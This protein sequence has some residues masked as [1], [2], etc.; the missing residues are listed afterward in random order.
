MIMPNRL[1][2][3]VMKLPSVKMNLQTNRPPNLAQ[4]HDSRFEMI[5]K[6]PNILSTCKKVPQVDFDKMGKHERFNCLINK[7][8]TVSMQRYEVKDDITKKRTNLGNIAI[9][10]Q[11][12]WGQIV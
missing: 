5:N 8:N 12:S 9:D 3:S 1:T 7:D 10:K 2:T 11:L 6:D 4:A